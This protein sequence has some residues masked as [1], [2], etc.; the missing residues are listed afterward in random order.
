MEN[1]SRNDAREQE[2]RPRER[3]TVA[4]LS[5]VGPIGVEDSAMGLDSSQ[6]KPTVSH[7]DR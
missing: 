1:G 6:A 4:T 5:V 7:A 2:E 3:Q